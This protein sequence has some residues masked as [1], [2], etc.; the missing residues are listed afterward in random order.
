MLAILVLVVGFCR[1]HPCPCSGYCT[2]LVSV[3]FVHVLG[4]LSFLLV[5]HVSVSFFTFRVLRFASLSRI[6]L[7]LS[8]QVFSLA[9]AHA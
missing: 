1:D 6:V 7:G 3:G 4:S 9:F 2:A 8:G 5:F